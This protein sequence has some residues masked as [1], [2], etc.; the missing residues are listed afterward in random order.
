VQEVFSREIALDGAD[1][2][3][4]G[5]VPVSFT[6]SIPN[7][8]SNFLCPP[9]LVFCKRGQTYGSYR[10]TLQYRPSSTTGTSITTSACDKSNIAVAY[11]VSTFG[12]TTDLEAAVASS[13]L[14]KSLFGPR[15][16]TSGIATLDQ[17]WRG[18][19]YYMN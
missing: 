13:V 19:A 3:E 11:S 15:A 18:Y 9:G 6:V 8:S 1:E 10:A 2:G 7:P 5:A 16:S 12:A 4:V 17:A 14:R